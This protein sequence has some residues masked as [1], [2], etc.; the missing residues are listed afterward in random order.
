MTST[1]KVDKLIAVNKCLDVTH[2][3][4]DLASAFIEGGKQSCYDISNN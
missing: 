4:G 3:R 2:Q 1:S